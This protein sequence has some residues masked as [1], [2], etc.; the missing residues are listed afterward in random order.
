[1]VD[2]LINRS[3]DYANRGGGWHGAERRLANERALDGHGSRHPKPRVGGIDV[4]TADYI[5]LRKTVAGHTNFASATSQAGRGSSPTAMDIGSIASVTDAEPSDT[6][7][8]GDV[9][10]GESWTFDEAAWPLDEEGWPVEGRFDEHSLNFVQGG[11][12]NGKGKGKGP[13]YNCGEMGI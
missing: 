1:M 9:K 5:L 4:E 12:G 13:C 2:S 6:A 7:P 8:R 11:K 10:Q 3:K